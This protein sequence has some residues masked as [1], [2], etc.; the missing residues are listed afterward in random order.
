MSNPQYK[1]KRPW[2]LETFLP[3]LEARYTS[4]LS[5]V[6]RQ[7]SRNIFLLDSAQVATQING[8][9]LYSS[10]LE[11]SNKTHVSKI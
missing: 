6:F 3:H 10:I 11:F 1:R 5:D 7:T 4:S 8:R 9:L 2:F